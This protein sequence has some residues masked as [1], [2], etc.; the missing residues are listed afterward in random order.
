MSQEY[1][2]DGGVHVSKNTV[3][4]GVRLI[5]E[6]MLTTQ[7]TTVYSDSGFRVSNVILSENHNT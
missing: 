3:V 4:I 2:E 7:N 5:I 6:I 1:M